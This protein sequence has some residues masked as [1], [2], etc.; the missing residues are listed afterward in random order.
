MRRKIKGFMEHIKDGITPHLP[1]LPN[2]EEKSKDDLP[3]TQKKGGGSNGGGEDDKKPSPSWWQ[4]NT[5][6]E[7]KWK[8]PEGQ[9]WA[10]FF[11]PA[12]EIGQTNLAHFP[13]I[14][15][16]N[17]FLKGLKRMCIKYQSGGTCRSNCNNAHCLPSK[18]S[19]DNWKQMDSAFAKAYAS[20]WHKQGTGKHNTLVPLIVTRMEERER[21][22]GS[23]N[24]ITEMSTPVQ[25]D[26]APFTIGTPTSN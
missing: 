7:E 3:S 5:E 18:L 10:K 8:P 2:M 25:K 12:N 13:K 1:S 11:N 14:Y 22:I 16:H 19:P 4:H 20:N 21:L 26:K 9:Q 24:D 23:L 6:Q 17:P 15:H